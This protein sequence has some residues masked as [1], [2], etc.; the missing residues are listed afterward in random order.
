[1]SALREL[2]TA[3][4]VGNTTV[5]TAVTLAP[6]VGVGLAAGGT[7]LLPLI[8][9][10]LAS[11]IG[12]ELV[13]RLARSQP[14]TYHGVT[15][16]LVLVVLLPS[17]IALWQAASM[18]VLGVTL[19]E[20]IFGGRGFAFLNAAVVSAA[21]IITSFPG[22]ALSELSSGHAVAALP[23]AVALLLADILP[24]RT[25]ATFLT[26]CLI[27]AGTVGS[28]IE[29]LAGAMLVGAVFLL[30]DPFA[31]AQT[32]TG[33]A[34]QGLFAAVIFLWL[35]DGGQ[36]SATEAIVRSALVTALFVPLF[37]HAVL[38]IGGRFDVRP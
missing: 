7:V 2:F 5:L 21:L 9:I 22:V 18:T 33:Q 38:F 34:F 6:V 8:A 26:A 23:A 29:P 31:S 27:V 28:G 16:A 12:T 24:W 20:M 11:A 25:L 19:G 1:M 37:D 15:T 14:L 3:R 32:R 10:V 30:C 17:D 13:F 4:S 35:A 36:A